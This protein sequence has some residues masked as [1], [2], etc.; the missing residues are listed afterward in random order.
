[1]IWQCQGCNSLGFY[2]TEAERLRVA[3]EHE[4]HSEE[5]FPGVEFER[6]SMESKGPAPD[7]RGWEPRGTP[8]TG[9]SGGVPD[10][11]RFS[12]PKDHESNITDPKP[13]SES[14]AIKAT[15]IAE[16]ILRA[17]RKIKDEEKL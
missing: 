12:H 13:L 16:E 5:G 3:Q 2:W 15:E 17:W 9:L 8:D 11:G 14:D 6:P 7:A 1:M 4:G 10:S